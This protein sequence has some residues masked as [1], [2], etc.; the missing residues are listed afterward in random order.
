MEIII[1][2][3][4]RGLGKELFDY[5]SVDHSVK[6]LSRSN[7]YDIVKDQEKILQEIQG[8]DLFINCAYSG[9]AQ[10][11]LLMS[12]INTVSNT[13]VIGTTMQNIQE[14]S[15]FP[16]I[17]DKKQLAEQ[18]RQ[19]SI[20]PTVSTNILLLNISF[21]PRKEGSLMTTDNHIDYTHVIDTINYWLKYKNISE[22]NFSWKM[23]EL[24]LSEFKRLSPS[25]NFT[26][27]ERTKND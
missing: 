22:I 16:Y 25:T 17:A 19:L 14:F 26:K 1:T 3:H 27:F 20:D 8:A 11:Q 9:N 13:I 15:N 10:E 5:Y 23:T 2:G 12:S 4:T 24:V 21:L 7:G 18:C 6:G